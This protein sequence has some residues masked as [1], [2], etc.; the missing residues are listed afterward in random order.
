[1][2]RH[3]SQ[4]VHLKLIRRDFRPDE[5][6]PVVT[7]GVSALSPCTT[8]PTTAVVMM[9]LEL[10]RKKAEE[11]AEGTKDEAREI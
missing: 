9:E 6:P 10:D 4:T 5:I 7:P 1:M 2:L 8:I 11:A 3:T